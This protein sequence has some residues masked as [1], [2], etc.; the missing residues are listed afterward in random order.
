MP[1]TL[2]RLGHSCVR[3]TTGDGSFSIDPGGFSDVA[4]A[5]DG[6]AVVL[7]THVHPDHVDVAALAA[8]DGVEVHAPA[9]VVDALVDAGARRDRLHPVRA[10]DVLDVAGARVEVLGE[11]HEV[12]H[13][14]LPRPANVAYL[15]DGVVLHPGDSYTQPPPGTQVDV[16]LE[17]V[18]APWLRLGDVV[19]HVRAVQPRRVVPVHDALLSDAG[20]ASAQR[21]LGQLTTAQIVPLATGEELAVA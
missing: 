10:G 2:T 4:A 8:A 20:R 15:V 6:V 3:V 13:A 18:G 16:L 11:V 12:I 9:E 14:D 17:A 21:L 5:L 1:L 7:V 19:D